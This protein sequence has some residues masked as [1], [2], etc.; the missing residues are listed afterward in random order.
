MRYGDKEPDTG[1]AQ[2]RENASLHRRLLHSLLDADVYLLPTVDIRGTSY[3]VPIKIG[4]GSPY[5]ITKRGVPE[6]ITVLG[7]CRILIQNELLE[8]VDTFPYLGSL[9]TEDGECSLRRNSAPG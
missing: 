6:L 8:Q 5:S 3:I 4:K 2:R 7:R 1:S 9:I